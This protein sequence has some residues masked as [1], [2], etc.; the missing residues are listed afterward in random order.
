M[1]TVPLDEHDRVRLD[2]GDAAHRHEDPVPMLQLD[3]QP[4]NARRLPVDA[5]HGHCVADPAEQVSV[6]IEDADAGE[7]GEEDPR[8]RAH[9]RGA[10]CCT[11]A[12]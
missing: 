10:R 11:P 12:G 2:P 1:L 9:D 5:Q 4:Q 7:P 6:G 8:H 3:D